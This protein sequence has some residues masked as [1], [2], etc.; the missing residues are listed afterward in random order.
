M[1]SAVELVEVAYLRLRIFTSLLTSYTTIA[2]AALF[3]YDVV[4]TF[5]TEVNLVWTK[6][7]TMITIF[8]LVN[9]YT[10]FVYQIIQI[11]L[12][13]NSPR[14]TIWIM[15]DDIIGASEGQCYEAIRNPLLFS[16]FNYTATHRF[17]IKTWSHVR[18]MDR[19]R[20]PSVATVL[21]SD[22]QYFY[23]LWAPLPLMYMPSSRRI[24]KAQT[25][26]RFSNVLA[27]LVTQV[28]FLLVGRLYLDLKMFQLVDSNCPSIQLGT[29]SF[30]S[31]RLLGN[32]GSH[33]VTHE[34][35]DQ[36]GSKL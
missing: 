34:D 30:A 9:K 6:P 27:P 21:L 8:Y 24:M 36:E 15:S 18:A 23:V 25:F 3:I 7:F 2:A 22:E 29:I 35:Q 11:V 19:M 12:Q 5:P 17:V 26:A 4:A 28:P 13:L 32:I 1:S 16:Y 10:Y 14:T 33:L 20:Q 31:N